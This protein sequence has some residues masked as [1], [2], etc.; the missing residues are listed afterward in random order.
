MTTRT[1]ASNGR[2]S[3]YQDAAGVWHG[4]VT[5]G[6]KP[7]GRLD[8]R[9]Q[10]GKSRAEVTEKVR[11]LERHRDGGT[12]TKAGQQPTVA[13]YMQSFLDSARL[14]L[15]YNSVRN[16]ATDVERHIGPVI[17]AL[18]MSSVRVDDIE[19]VYATMTAAGLSA[20]TVAHARRTLSVAFN[21]AVKRGVIPRSPVPLASAATVTVRQ[22]AQRRPWQHGCADEPCGRKPA[23]CPQRHGGGI[24]YD[25]PKSRAGGRTLA[26]PSQL[27]DTLKVH[28][29]RQ[30]EERL[31][32]G[33]RWQDHGLV[34]THLDGRS[35][36]PADHSQAWRAILAEAGVRPARLHDARHTAATLLLVQGVDPRVVMALMGWSHLSLTTRYQHVVP[37]LARDAADRIGEALWGAT[38]TANVTAP[39]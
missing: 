3:I 16:Y 25:T 6:T 35:I 39:V 8:R 19:K 9:H 22:Q 14:R 36:D 26:L 32:A 10:R 28:R 18:R 24:V 11:E 21:H 15:K 34:F 4:K 31:R 1:R 17:G 7:D 12:V 5:V 23:R 13:D 38:V 30:R 20:S 27:V 33:S 37:E 2:S 29:Q